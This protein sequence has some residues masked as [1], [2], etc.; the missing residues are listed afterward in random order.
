MRE[1]EI[2][3]ELTD[4]LQKSLRS[5]TIEWAMNLRICDIISE[6]PSLAATTV[7]YIGERLRSSTPVKVYLVR[8]PTLSTLLHQLVRTVLAAISWTPV[9][10]LV[11]K[12]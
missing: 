8:G 3:A 2:K 7:H 4:M 9:W 6:R 1:G 12:F 5:N 11:H 10:N